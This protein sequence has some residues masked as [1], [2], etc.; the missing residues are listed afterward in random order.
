M[1]IKP[2]ETQ[3]V[4]KWL[5]RDGRIVG[6]ETCKR[7]DEL[8]T[9]HLKELGRDPGGWDAL[10]RNSN[11]GRL[12][13]LTYSS[14]TSSGWRS[15]ATHL[16]DI[17]RGKEEIR[18]GQSVPSTCPI[19]DSGSTRHLCSHATSTSASTFSECTARLQ[20]HQIF[21]FCPQRLLLFNCP[22]IESWE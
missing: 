21:D 4:G 14:K 12:W 15:S 2:T 5:S 9:S 7:I 6:D 16:S 19:G 1:K 20:S 13:E 10:Y 22:G 3:L 18:H 8:I 17:R 11:D